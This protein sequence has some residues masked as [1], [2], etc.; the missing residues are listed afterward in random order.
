[1]H[2]EGTQNEKCNEDGRNEHEGP[3]FLC[4]YGAVYCLL[5]IC[6]T[7][8]VCSGTAVVQSLRCCATNRKVACSIPV[9]VI[10]NFS[11]T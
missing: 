8:C 11:L 6:T 10:G 3:L 1:M 5:I 4:T 9:G 2:K 7:I